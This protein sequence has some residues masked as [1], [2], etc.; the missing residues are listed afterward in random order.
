MSYYDTN[1]Q[2]RI[3]EDYTSLG[4]V[5]KTVRRDPGTLTASANV[6]HR[7]DVLTGRSLTGL[8]IKSSGGRVTKFTGSEARTLYRVLNKAIHG[9][10]Q[11]Q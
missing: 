4:A 1:S 10:Q 11:Q 8:E 7:N 9:Q 5:V 2:A 6:R 3:I